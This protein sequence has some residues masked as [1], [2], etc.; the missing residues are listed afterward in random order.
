MATPTPNLGLVKP[1][2]SDEVDQTIPALAESLSKID[3][4]TGKLSALTT[5]DKSS[6]VG[7]ISENSNGIVALKADIAT[8]FVKSFGAIGDGVTDDTNAIK[9]ALQYA[10]SNN[11][12][13]ITFE[14]SKRYKITS[15]IIIPMGTVKNFEIDFNYA[16][17]YMGS[18][19][20]YY[21]GLISLNFDTTQTETSLIVKNGWFD[22]TGNAPDWTTIPPVGGSG[23]V[24]AEGAR[25][26]IVDNCHF[27]DWFYT[28][29]IFSLYSDTIK[30]TNCTGVNVG[31]IAP[32]TTYD[33]AGDAIYLGYTGYYAS[34]NHKEA[35][36]LIENCSFKAHT[37]VVPG[38]PGP[39]NSFHSG[40]CGVVL[41]EYATNTTAKNI[42]VNNC[43]F[44]NY[45]RCFH[46]ENT[47]SIHLNVNDSSFSECGNVVLIS[48]DNTWDNISFKNCNFVKNND[49]RGMTNGF[50]HVIKGA[51][52]SL[53]DSPSFTKENVC[54]LDTCNFAG[55]IS[56]VGGMRA[57]DVIVDNCLVE[58]Y[59]HYFYNCRI[60]GINSKFK[61]NSNQVNGSYYSFENCRIELGYLHD[62]NSI[63]VLSTTS[64]T[65]ESKLNKNSTVKNCR[66]INT[67]FYQNVGASLYFSD[68]EF[69][70]DSNFSLKTY[71]GVT[72]NG[73]LDLGV[74][75]IRVIE[76]C[77]FINSSGVAIPLFVF[78]VPTTLDDVFVSKNQFKGITINSFSSGCY[79]K[80]NFD[81]NKFYANGLTLTYF[82]KF[83]TSCLI[84][85]RNNS[86]N[87]LASGEIQVPASSILL[88]N[89]RISGSTAT[90]I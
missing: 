38:D 64:G 12:K 23:V 42:T 53:N 89:Y 30:I 57:T 47:R 31:G 44:Y 60:K 84:F 7:A 43:H 27:N 25:T 87:D 36:V 6:L 75:Q 74:D 52:D 3:A 46:I 85:A 79:F 50:N 82:I 9:T 90:A 49:V 2:M 66:L 88:N 59:Y 71:S 41:C 70:F 5:I 54:K 4:A 35:N 86:F 29:A 72:I 11:S 14:K 80:I 8:T 34:G 33:A 45:Q 32:T 10:V 24:H 15:P 73:L 26:Y 13:G 67:T 39:I 17:I 21:S 51:N 65:I 68:N 77:K 28:S 1:D 40:R 69:T 56:L 55:Y 76:N 48:H 63:Y 58:S 83:Q 20:A 81:N 62:T 19:F 61:I 37:L 16:C 78:T 18:K 22:G